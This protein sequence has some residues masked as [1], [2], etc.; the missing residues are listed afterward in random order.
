MTL[1]GE[2]AHDQERLCQQ[3]RPA[4]GESQPAEIIAGC[5]LTGLLHICCLRAL[6]P[7]DDFKFDGISFL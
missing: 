2:G 7:L 1:G 5:Y 4:E 3:K 6:R